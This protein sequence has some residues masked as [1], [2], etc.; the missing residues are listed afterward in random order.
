MNG[1]S[2]AILATLLMFKKILLTATEVTE[3]CIQEIDS[4][5]QPVSR[6]ESACFYSYIRYTDLCYQEL[7]STVLVQLWAA[8]WMQ[9]LPLSIIGWTVVCFSSSD[10][11]YHTSTWHRCFTRLRL[12]VPYVHLICCILLKLRL[13]VPSIHL[14]Q[15]FYQAQTE[16][17][18]HPPDIDVLPGFQ[19]CM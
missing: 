13:K 8:F 15:M 11:K 17:T 3:V 5:F 18:I 14:T 19:Y 1:R 9:V 6:L 16:S 2:W 10:W 4:C 7:L 12:K